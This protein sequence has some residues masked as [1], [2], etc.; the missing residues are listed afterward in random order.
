MGLFSILFIIVTVKLA[1]LAKRIKRD[2]TAQEP[3]IEL[4]DGIVKMKR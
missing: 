3:V 1:F 4:E 2:M